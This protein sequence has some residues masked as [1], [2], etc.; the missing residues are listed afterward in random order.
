VW[1]ANLLTDADWAGGVVTAT[2]TTNHGVLPGDQISIQGVT[3]IGY[4]GVHV[5]LS[6]TAAAVLKYAVPTDPG[7]PSGT[8]G[9]LLASKYGAQ[10]RPVTEFGHA[11][12]FFVTLNYNPGPANRVPQLAFSYLYGVTPFPT[13]GNSALIRNMD[14]SYT[15]YIGTGAEGGMPTNTILFNGL[16]MDGRPF[17]YW[18]SV[19]Y[20]QINAKLF[21]ANAVINGSNTTINPLYYKQ[22][23][24]NR[25]QQALVGM[26]GSAITAGLVLGSIVQL[27][28]DIISLGNVLSSGRYN[29]QVVI[30]AVPFV[31]YS[32]ANPTHYRQGIYNGLSVTFTPLAGFRSITVDINVTD[33]VG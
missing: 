1:P 17:N 12:D 30:N 23:G 6:G 28:L 2:T 5:A 13:L 31:P 25:L 14:D 20:V 27:E 15:N 26:M 7:A 4:N 19:D 11:S 32:I 16:T 22:D 10:A 24:I 18:Y 9:T 33:F 21:I 8:G 29:G 3:P